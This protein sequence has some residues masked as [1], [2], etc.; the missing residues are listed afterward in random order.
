MRA[1]VQRTHHSSVTVDGA[2]VGEVGPGLTI[3]LGVAPEDGPA[4]LRW[5]AQKVANLRIFADDQGRMNLSL[6]DKGFGALVISQFTLYGDCSK[7]RR[8]SFI[9]AARPELAEP[10]YR[11]F[12]DALAA[13]GV[14]PVAR[15][16]FGADMQ[17]SLL[18][19]GPVT[20][21][22]DTPPQR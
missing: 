22:I 10:L 8:P 21:V 13:E 20:L 2:V 4:Q 17:V 12:C 1:V 18:N 19:D 6:K 9:S 15:G 11:Q 5:L 14:H 16:V 3:L 7:G